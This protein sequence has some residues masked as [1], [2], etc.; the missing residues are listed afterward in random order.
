ML[1]LIPSS[2]VNFFD[3]MFILRESLVPP[4]FLVAG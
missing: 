3:F 2:G 4:G 1:E